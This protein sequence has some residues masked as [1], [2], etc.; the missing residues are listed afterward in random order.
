MN[1][2][3]AIMKLTVLY[4]I[5]NTT[6]NLNVNANTNNDIDNNNSSIY[7]KTSGGV[8]SFIKNNYNP[9]MTSDLRSFMNY[10][11]EKGEK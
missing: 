11:K 4:S 2:F 5:L 6:G 10:N 7:L 3:P 8:N 9:L 1:Q